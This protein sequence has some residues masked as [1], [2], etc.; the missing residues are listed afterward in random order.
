[1]LKIII[2][3]KRL[4]A[5]RQSAIKGLG[6]Y[7]KEHFPNAAFGV[8]PIE[9]DSKVAIVIVSNKYSPSNFW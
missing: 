7:V 2:S 3:L 1:V 4:T 6:S 8:Y 5:D 9:S